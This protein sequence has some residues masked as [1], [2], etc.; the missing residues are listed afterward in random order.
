MAVQV[1][2]RNPVLSGSRRKAQLGSFMTRELRPS[3]CVYRRG[4]DASWSVFACAS[5]CSKNTSQIA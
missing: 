3:R 5:C 1:W 4:G 2:P